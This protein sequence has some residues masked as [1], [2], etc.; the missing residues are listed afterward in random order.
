MRSSARELRRDHVDL[1]DA[2]IAV[3]EVAFGLWFAGTA[4]VNP[5]FRERMPRT[6]GAIERSLD[7]LLPS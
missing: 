1:L 6:M 2:F 4:E 5:A 7:L 3:R